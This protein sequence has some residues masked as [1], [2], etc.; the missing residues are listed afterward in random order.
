MILRFIALSLALVIAAAVQAADKPA[1]AETTAAK[2]DAAKG[3][4]IA[5]QIC[6]ACHGPDGNSAVAA[7]PKLAGQHADYLYKQLK[8]FKTDGGK[9]AERSNPIMG[10]M[11]AAL[12]DQDMKNVAAWYA[13]QAQKGEQ[14]K[15]RAIEAAQ[16]L[17]RAGDAAR[18]L[19]ACAACHGPA[20][21]G[22]P[23]QYPRIGG[24]FSEYTEAQLIAFRDGSRANDPNKM[25]RAIA[26][27]MS[28]AEIKAIA[29]YVAG[30]R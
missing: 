5:A 30:L 3:Q 14:A 23:A 1:T 15:A 18:G 17:Y 29:D 26:A 13:S 10:G 22:I 2:A 9:P 20:G 27:T 28:S 4:Q 7:N 11:V 6:A 8:N 12:S 19:P 16:K 24:Q 21:A 25:M